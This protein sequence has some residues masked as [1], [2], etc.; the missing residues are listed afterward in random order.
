[1]ILQQHLIPR[2]SV[3]MHKELRHL[4]S[5]VVSFR[6]FSLHL[7]YLYEWSLCPQ[8]YHQKK[9]DY[10]CAFL[11]SGFFLILL[12]WSLFIL[13]GKEVDHDCYDAIRR[14]VFLNAVSCRDMTQFCLR[15][16]FQEIGKEIE[17]TCCIVFLMLC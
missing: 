4:R 14:H 5:I 1:M 7:V 6:F 15:K 16:C 10:L 3:S 9:I 2:F 11:L 8:I 13:M 17:D 12:F